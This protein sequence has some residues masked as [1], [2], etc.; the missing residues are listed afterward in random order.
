MLILIMALCSPVSANEAMKKHLGS[1]GALPDVRKEL[2][3]TPA[4]IS[5]LYGTRILRG[6]KGFH[7]GIDIAVARGTHVKPLLEGIVL[8][9]GWWGSYGNMVE[10][11]HGMGVTTR[12][13]HLSAVDVRPLTYVKKGQTIGRVGSTGRSTGNHLHFELRIRGKAV[14]PML[15][16]RTRQFASK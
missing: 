12:Y 4:R 13:A 16:N 3:K 15:L 6:K 1:I 11:Y 2:G 8:R 10:V 5:S 7:K 14:D 9:A